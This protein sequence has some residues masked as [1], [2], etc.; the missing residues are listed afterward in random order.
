MGAAEHAPRGSPEPPAQPLARPPPPWASCPGPG[1]NLRQRTGLRS[2]YHRRLRG[3]EEKETFAPFPT[4]ESHPWRRWILSWVKKNPVG[5]QNRSRRL[6]EAPRN[7]GC[8]EFAGGKGLPAAGLPTLASPWPAVTEGKR[9]NWRHFG[10]WTSLTPV[11][12]GGKGLRPL[13][14]EEAGPGE[15][16]AGAGLGSGPVFSPPHPDL[17]LVA[18]VLPAPYTSNPPGSPICPS[19]MRL[20]AC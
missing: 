12:L 20:A 16:A 2:P 5:P 10:R 19:F 18:E 13:H 3:T 1:T 14:E 8:R 4:K 11:S 17:L 6:P 9:G 7:H 15:P